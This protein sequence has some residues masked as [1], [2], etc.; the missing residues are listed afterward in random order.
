METKFELKNAAPAEN[1]VEPVDSVT[2]GDTK[3]QSDVSDDDA[4]R[5]AATA[6]GQYV[7]GTSAEKRLVRKIDFILLPALWW[8]YVLAYVDRGNVVSIE[9]R[10][11]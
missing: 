3:L 11:R 10:A 4:E 8:L 2:V 5:G 9:A 1:I 7:P 6:L